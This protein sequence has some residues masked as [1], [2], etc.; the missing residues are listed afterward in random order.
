MTA[1]GGVYYDAFRYSNTFRSLIITVKSENEKM[2]AAYTIS[3]SSGERETY[4]EDGLLT[5]YTL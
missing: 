3:Y 2:P 4:L 5:G 1:L